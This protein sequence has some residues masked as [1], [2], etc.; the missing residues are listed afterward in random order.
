MVRKLKYHEA[1]LLRKLDFINW[2]SDSSVREN[3][4]LRRYHVQDREDYHTYNKVCGMITKLVTLLKALDERDPVRIE[5]T[6]LLLD[7]LHSLGIVQNKRLL[8][9][10]KIA[11][12]TL[13]RRRLPVVLVR[14]KFAET[15]REAVQLVEQGHVRVGP[16]P[17][18][19]PAYLVSRS[20]EDYVTWVDTSRIKRTIMKYNDKLDDFDL[21]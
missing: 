1:T 6:D 2:K 17:V 12:S 4:I 13:C 16:Y 5:V 7:K 21:L 19:D 8:A 18:T 3:K 14:L 15:M 10:E 11:A 20:M 9:C